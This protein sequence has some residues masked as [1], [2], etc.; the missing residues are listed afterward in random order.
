[1]TGGDAEKTAVYIL[2]RNSEGKSRNRNPFSCVKFVSFSSSVAYADAYAEDGGVSKV[3]FVD[4]FIRCICADKFAVDEEAV[5]TAARG[6]ATPLL[7]RAMAFQVAASSSVGTKIG[8]VKMNGRVRYN[9][10]DMRESYRSVRRFRQDEFD[11]RAKMSRCN[12]TELL[13][14]GTPKSTR[15]ASNSL[16]SHVRL[17]SLYNFTSREVVRT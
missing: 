14:A 8:E 13:W 16:A 11:S 10:L 6:P 15:L 9:S 1:M 7:P 12:G 4:N 5:A 3:G 17:L 2:V